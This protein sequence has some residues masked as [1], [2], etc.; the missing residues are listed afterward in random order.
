P[1]IRFYAGAPIIVPDGLILGTFCIIDN[2]PRA[3]FSKQDTAKLQ[4]MAT[5]CSYLIQSRAAGEAF[6]QKIKA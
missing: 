5:T 1:H 3:S 6:W 4:E 2:K